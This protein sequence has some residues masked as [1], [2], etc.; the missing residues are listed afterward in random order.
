M[1]AGQQS[2]VAAHA[3]NIA[4]TNAHLLPKL[5][6]AAAMQKNV[7]MLTPFEDASSA[8]CRGTTARKYSEEP[9]AISV[10]R[11]ATTRIGVTAHH[12]VV[13]LT[14]LRKQKKG[15]KIKQ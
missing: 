5:C 9:M 13:E 8:L 14:F 2:T 6:T 4:L 7:T 11:L 3:A 12:A 15:K 10:S 1:C